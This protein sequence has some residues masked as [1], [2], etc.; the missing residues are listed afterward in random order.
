ME[1]R[2]AK[3]IVNKSGGT[4]GKNSNTYR[5]TLPTVWIK[6]MGLG[7]NDREIELEYDPEKK[8][9]KVSKKI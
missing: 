7:E 3:L 4:S 8:L 9:I 6:D 1:K 2:K 5:A